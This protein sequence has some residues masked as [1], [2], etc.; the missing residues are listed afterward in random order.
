VRVARI[1]YRGTDREI[2]ELA[3]GSS[4]FVLKS[5]RESSQIAADAEISIEACRRLSE[6][7]S[8]RF[9]KIKSVE[10]LSRREYSR[11][12]L[13]SKLSKF[14]LSEAGV[15]SA[16]DEL[17]ELG[18]VSDERFARAWLRSRLQRAP[19]AEP[20]LVSGLAKRGVERTLAR[21]LARKALEGRED[22]VL[23]EAFEK[24]CRRSSSRKKVLGALARRGFS[25]AHI[26]RVLSAELDALCD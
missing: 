22:E 4:F 7:S 6:E 26:Q 15:H 14:A 19:E 12:Q 24:A 16:L 17:A 20:L 8:Y 11:A 2:I 10:Y 9:A 13:V 3:D 1:E 25:Y 23:R 21:E 5:L 18:Y